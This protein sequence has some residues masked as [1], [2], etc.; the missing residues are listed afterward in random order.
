V[1]VQRL[2]SALVLVPII[3]ATIYL[4]GWWYV[5]LVTTAAILAVLE[6]YNVLRHA[7]LHPLL[8]LMLIFTAALMLTGRFPSPEAERA[9][10]A[11][12]LIAVSLWQLA[13]PVD[14][15]SLADWGMTIT[16]A[17]YIGWL[18]AAV[19]L[20][21][22]GPLGL[23]W[24]VFLF[25]T[26]WATDTAAYFGG[27]A[28]GRMPFAP[29]ISPKKTWEGAV[30]GWLLAIVLAVATTRG[31]GL[32]MGDLTA[33]ALGLVVSLVATM[34]DLTMSFV[35]RQGHVKDASQLIPGHGGLLDRVDSLMPAAA[36][37]HIFIW[38]TS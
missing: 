3:I 29:T 14:R 8:P 23:Q 38:W 7:G 26:V 11:I 12:A 15:R 33:A 17:L 9:V 19:L 22:F 6:F 24:T 31:L 16:P 4:G 2:G 25:V 5:G 10:I 18:G 35:K 34:G 32:P 21:R 13:R 37:I 20:I 28:F 27:R 1:L 30:T 36:V